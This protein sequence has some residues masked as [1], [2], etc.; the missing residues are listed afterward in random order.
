MHSE[1]TTCSVSSRGN[2]VQMPLTDHIAVVTGA[3][4]GIGRAIALALA[5]HGATVCL[6]GRDV[7]ALERVATSARQDGARAAWYPADLASDA[8]LQHVIVQLQRDC[9]AIDILVHSAGVIALGRMER[10]DVQE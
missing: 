8:D 5:A 4:S 10:A 2:F 9:E 3:S 7:A 1:S 6:I